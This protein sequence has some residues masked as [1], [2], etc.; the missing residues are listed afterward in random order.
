[1]FFTVIAD[2]LVVRAPFQS[3]L[4]VC[5]F[6]NVQPTVQLLIAVVPAFTVTSPWKPPGYWL[7]TL[8]VAVQPPPTGGGVVVGGALAEVRGLA[9]VLRGVAV[10]VPP[11]VGGTRCGCRML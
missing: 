11:P 4:I 8:Y 7:I 10:C 1:M 3:W 2:P 9:R 6:W 5:P